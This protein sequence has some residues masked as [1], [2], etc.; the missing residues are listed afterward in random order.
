MAGLVQWLLSRR[1]RLIVLAAVLASV[2]V[3]LFVSSALMTLETLYRGPRN[4]A[5]SALAA[6]VAGIPLAWVWGAGPTGLLLEVRR[7][8]LRRRRAG[9]IVCGAPARW[10]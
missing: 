7:R 1:Y 3:V 2:P 4:G 10:R 8:A 5:F 6:T 9:R